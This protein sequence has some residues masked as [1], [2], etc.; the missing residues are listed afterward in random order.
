MANLKAYQKLGRAVINQALSDAAW[1][2]SLEEL[3]EYVDSVREEAREWLKSGSLEVNGFLWACQLAG[4]NPDKVRDRLN[5]T[6]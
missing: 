5:D 4:W 6:N 3:A 1:E 2:P